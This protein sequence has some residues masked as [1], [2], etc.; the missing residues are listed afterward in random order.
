[1][2][3]WQVVTLVEGGVTSPVKYFFIGAIPEL[4]KSRLLS[5]FGI[6]EKLGSLKCPLLSKNERY[7]SLKSFNDVHSIALLP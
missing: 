3:F 2:H 7:F 1:M 4:I 5:L 6:R